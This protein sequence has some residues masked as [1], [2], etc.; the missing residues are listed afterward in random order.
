MSRGHPVD[1]PVGHAECAPHVANGGARAHGAEGDDLRHVVAPVFVHDEPDH[2][3]APV[4]LEVHVDVRHFLAL[5]VQEALE[6]KVV[7]QRVHVRDAQAEEHEAGGGAA[8]HTEE[9]ALPARVREDVPDHKEV[10]GELGVLDDGELVVEALVVAIGRAGA[11]P[12]E[13]LAAEALQVRLRLRAIGSLV[14]GQPDAVE[15][16]ADVAGVGDALGVLDGL[17]ELRK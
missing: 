8:P 14:L 2:L 16:E 1:V 10:V 5:Q 4:V 12:L 13:A 17:R 15:V 9:D 7:L 6:D 11:Q 3:V